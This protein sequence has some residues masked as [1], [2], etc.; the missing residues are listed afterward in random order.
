M[1]PIATCMEKNYCFSSKGDKRGMHTR[2]APTPID[3]AWGTEGSVVP[4]APKARLP[5]PV[6]SPPPLA[7]EL[8]PI[9][10][11]PV[12]RTPLGNIDCQSC[13]LGVL[14]GALA[15]MMIMFVLLNKRQQAEQVTLTRLLLAL[16]SKQ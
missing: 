14:M 1:K 12:A 4:K 11:L 6:E 16:A 3:E 13:I 2:A 5:P 8:A 10:P 15:G 9:A 7:A